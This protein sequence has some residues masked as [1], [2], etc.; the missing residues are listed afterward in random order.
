MDLLYNTLI[1]FASK[2]WKLARKMKNCPAALAPA[3][4]IG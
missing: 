4:K 1:R 3:G 2:E